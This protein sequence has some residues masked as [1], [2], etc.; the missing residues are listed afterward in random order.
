MPIE[1]VSRMKLLVLLPLSVSETRYCGGPPLPLGG[2]F[3]S[4]VIGTKND[5]P[6]PYMFH[7]ACAGTPASANTTAPARRARCL[8]EYLST[9]LHSP[10]NY[11]VWADKHRLFGSCA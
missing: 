8:D 11:G 1:P 4:V 9:F 3:D 2:R 10:K 5:P 6:L 7:C